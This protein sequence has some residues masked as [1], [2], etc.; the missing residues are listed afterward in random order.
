VRLR[1]VGM[2]ILTDGALDATPR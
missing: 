1:T 2:L